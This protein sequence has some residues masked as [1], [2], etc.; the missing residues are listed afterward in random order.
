LLGQDIFRQRQDDRTGPPGGRHLKRA[1]QVLWDAIG[2][3]DF[4][5][6]LRQRRKHLAELD[7]LK[8]FTTADV[9][10]HLADK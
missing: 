5:D 4:R 10:L 7:L 1:K 2:R 6:P 8:R 3:F 9:A